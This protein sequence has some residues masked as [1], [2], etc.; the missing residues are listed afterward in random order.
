M[1]GNKDD[2]DDLFSL[3]VVKVLLE[4]PEKLRKIAHPG[5]WL[6]MIAQN[7]CTDLYR[8]RQSDNRKKQCFADLIPVLNCPP[9]SPEESLLTAELLAHIDRALAGL[10]PLLRKVAELRFIDEVSYESIAATLGITQANARKRVQ[11]ARKELATTL[12][13]YFTC[14]RSL[15]LRAPPNCHP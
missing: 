13:T 7:Q 8:Q 1:N 9:V 14:E 10:P 6:A 3:I 15:F 12:S 2:A 5:G 11:K 4:D